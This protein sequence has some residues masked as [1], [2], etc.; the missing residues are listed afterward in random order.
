MWSLRFEY[1]FSKK[2]SI[3]FHCL[4]FSQ[5]RAPINEQ[6][7]V[8]CCPCHLSHACPIAVQMLLSRIRILI[9]KGEHIPS[10]SNTAE[11]KDRTIL[12]VFFG[13]TSWS[14]PRQAMRLPV[15]TFQLIPKNENECGSASKVFS[16]FV[17]LSASGIY[18]LTSSSLVM[19]FVNL[20]PSLIRRSLTFW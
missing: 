9:V 6:F 7:W 8:F 17:D 3:Y 18:D 13:G 5:L 1:L 2:R 4:E 15:S 11:K 10:G 19:L 14:V 12:W 16:T 20:N